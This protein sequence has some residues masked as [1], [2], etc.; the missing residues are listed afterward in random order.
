MFDDLAVLQAEEVGECAA[1][2]LDVA[3]LEVEVGVGGDQVALADDALDVEL[4]VR[5]L[6][7]EPLDKADERLRAILGVGVVLDLAGAEVVGDGLLGVPGK[8]RRV[9][10]DDDLLVVLEVGHELEGIL[11]LPS[12][13]T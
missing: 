2:I 9:V 5:V 7:A 13:S 8:R 3:G 10:V 12:T 4:E 6:A 11:W 1:R